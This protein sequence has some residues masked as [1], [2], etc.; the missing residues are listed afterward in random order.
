MHIMGSQS[1]GLCDIGTSEHSLEMEVKYMKTN[2][3]L[4]SGLQMNKHSC[5][6]CIQYTHCRDIS[7]GVCF[8]YARSLISMNIF[9]VELNDHY[10][11]VM[12]VA[13]E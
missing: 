13:Y 2:Q 12:G 9:E 6:K 11:F 8:K 4:I 7:G 3:I 1:E 10:D 5:E